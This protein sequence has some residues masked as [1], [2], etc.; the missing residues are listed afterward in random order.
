MIETA[1]S[2]PAT[3]QKSINEMFPSLGEPE[4]EPTKKDEGPAKGEKKEKAW[5]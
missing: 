1:K 5:W 3:Y 2:K 4:T